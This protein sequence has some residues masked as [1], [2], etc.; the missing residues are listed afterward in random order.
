MFE[1]EMAN[2]CY[3]YLNKN[4]K[5]Y[6]NIVCEVPFLSR[7]I[8]LVLLTRNEE[9]IA[10]EFKIKNWRQAIEQARSHLLGADKVYICLPQRKPSLLLLNTLES[11]KIGLYLYDPNEIF[12]MKE[13]LP[14]PINEKK[15]T[16]FRNMLI[17]KVNKISNKYSQ[18]F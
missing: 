17:D 6:T 9:A 1:M 4:K 16:L 3:K 5:E 10:I 8:D 2:K 18:S 15:V 14:A 7:C 11:E 13:Y 12:V